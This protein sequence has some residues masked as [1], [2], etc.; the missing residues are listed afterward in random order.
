MCYLIKLLFCVNCER[1]TLWLLYLIYLIIL[2]FPLADSTRAVEI[3]KGLAEMI[4]K[5]LQPLSVVEDDGFRNFDTG[6]S[7]QNSK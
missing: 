6:S 4:V 5:D 2:L 3:T 7:V 1:D